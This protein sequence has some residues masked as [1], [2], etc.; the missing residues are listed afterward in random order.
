MLKRA[1]THL[2]A[3][4]LLLAGSLAATASPALAASAYWYAGGYQ[5]FTGTLPTGI[6]ANVNVYSPSLDTS[7]DAHTLTELAIRKNVVI[8]GT[9]YTQD[10]EV[11]WTVDQGQ[12]G[13]TSPHLFTTIWVNGV[14]QGYGGPGFVQCNTVAGV[15]NCGQTTDVWDLNDTLTAG[16]TM[17]LGIQYVPTGSK[18]GWWIIAYLNTGT[19]EFIGYW[20]STKWTTATPSITTFTDNDTMYAFGEVATNS[21]GI[22]GCSDMGDGTL[23][24]TTTGGVIGSV[25]AVGLASAAVDIDQHTTINNPSYYNMVPVAGSGGPGN[26]R[27]IRYGGPGPC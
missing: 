12:F 18:I 10:V 2:A 4:S 27:T 8:G 17:K 6:T 3:V 20:P 1:L 25:S 15:N 5:T 26:I 13:N 21:G 16:T 23:P 11:G 14:F 22:L 19:P 24:T 9:T 7:K